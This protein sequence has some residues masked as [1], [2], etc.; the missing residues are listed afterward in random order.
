M[1][2]EKELRAQVESYLQ[3]A[4]LTEDTTLYRATLTEF[5]RSNEDGELIIS[6]NADPSEAVVNVYEQGHVYL[7]RD[8][9][10]GLAF[11]ETLDN[12]WNADD[13]KLVSIQVKDVLEQGG[14]IYPVESV[15]TDRVWY[16][17]LPHGHIRVGEP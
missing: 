7:A 3:S 1:N 17:T 11:V 14:K 10:P 13:R 12:E 2:D 15:I 9:G 8:V 6:A 16:V 5:I 4:G